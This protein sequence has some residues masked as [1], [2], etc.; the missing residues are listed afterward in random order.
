M[1]LQI[2]KSS[3]V[4]LRKL[5]LEGKDTAE[6]YKKEAERIQKQKEALDA[7]AKG[8]NYGKP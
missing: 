1:K 8:T 4:E 2:W 5:L 7:L 6:F 3:S